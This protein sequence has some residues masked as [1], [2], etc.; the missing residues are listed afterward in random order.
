ME[1]KCNMSVTSDGFISERRFIISIASIQQWYPSIRHEVPTLTSDQIYL[2]TAIANFGFF[3]SSQIHDAVK[4]AAEQL[5]QYQTDDDVFRDYKKFIVLVTDGDEN[6]SENSLNQ[7]IQAVDFIDGEGEV[8]IVPVQLGQPHA[9]DSVLL[10]KYAESGNSRVFY[11][12][13]DLPDQ[14]NNVCES[15]VS[16]NNLQINTTTLTGEVVFEVPNIPDVIVINGVTVPDG[17]EAVYRVRTSIDGI[18]FTDWSQ[19]IDH[20]IPFEF[21]T[22]LDSLQKVVQYEIKLVGNTSFES[23][24]ITEGVEI[25][26]YNPREFVIFFKPISVNLEDDEYISSIHITSE[27]DIP[28]NSTVEFLMT[29]S[30]SLR[31]EEYYDV[32]PDQHTILPTRFNEVLLTDDFKT[33]RAINGRWNS[34]ATIEVYRLAEANTQG[35]LISASEYSAN[36]TEG[37]ITFLSSQDPSTTIFM[38]VFFASSFRIATRVTNFAEEAAVIHHIGVMYNISKRIPRS[39]D[40]TIIHVPISKRLPE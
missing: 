16:G 4:R 10:E 6:T 34:N 8:Q 15:I 17:A 35:V 23:P 19:F 14:I 20:S 26:Y 33:F 24:Q 39:S 12:D 36:A 37:T 5:V 1:L 38:N 18:T 13:D 40:G 32:V 3:G 21:E 29:Q 27:A 22:S 11:L 31:P 7:A 25:N 9:S 2:D 28:A 30:N